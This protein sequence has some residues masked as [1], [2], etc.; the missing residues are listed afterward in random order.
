MK[1]YNEINVV[2]PANTAFILKPMAQGV[3]LIFKPYYLRTTFHK[4]IAVI[5]SDSLMNLDKVTETLESIHQDR[6]Y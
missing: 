5:D 4:D 1:M 6:C 3:I 2:M